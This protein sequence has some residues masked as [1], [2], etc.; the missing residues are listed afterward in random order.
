MIKQQQPKSRMTR[1][2]RHLLSISLMSLLMD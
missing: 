1:R 2:R